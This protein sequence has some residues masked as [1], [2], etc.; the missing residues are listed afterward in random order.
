MWG[1]SCC[2]VVDPQAQT[3]IDPSLSPLRLFASAI[4]CFVWTSLL[5]YLNSPCMS[6]FLYHISSQATLFNIKTATPQLPAIPHLLAQ[7]TGTL[8][9][10]CGS[11]YMGGWVTCKYE[12]PRSRFRPS[13]HP[14]PTEDCKDSVHNRYQSGISHT[15]WFTKSVSPVSCPKVWDLFGKPWWVHAFDIPNQEQ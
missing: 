10:T 4:L 8:A 11:L 5:Y 13:W 15:I 1:G 2:V 6:M 9:H 12:R 14:S 3:T 7:C